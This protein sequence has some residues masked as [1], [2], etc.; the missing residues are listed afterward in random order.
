MLKPKFAFVP[1]NL[2]KPARIVYGR[3]VESFTEEAGATCSNSFTKE[4]K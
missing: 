1:A 4:V 2:A 3:F